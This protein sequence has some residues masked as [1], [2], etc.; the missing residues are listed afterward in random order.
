M[1]GPRP[2]HLQHISSTFAHI[3]AGQQEP[4]Q[5]KINKQKELSDLWLPGSVAF[6]HS[7]PAMESQ[8]HLLE[9]S[10]LLM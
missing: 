5:V 6:S 7:L 8:S 9:N 2:V 1:Q 10:P 3:R 4:Q